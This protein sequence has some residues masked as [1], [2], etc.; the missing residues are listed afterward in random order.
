VR[1]IKS[2]KPLQFLTA[3][4]CFKSRLRF[5]RFRHLK[6]YSI[7]SIYAKDLSSSS[8]SGDNAINT[9]FFNIFYHQEKIE[10]N[11]KTCLSITKNDAMIKLGEIH[12]RNNLGLIL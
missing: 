3:M 10:Y 5:E 6:K 12:Q 8:C 7:S 4:Q 11:G 1:P 2:A 9:D